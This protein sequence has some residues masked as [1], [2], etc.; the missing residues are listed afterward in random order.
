MTMVAKTSI[1]F[2]ALLFPVRDQFVAHAPYQGKD[3]QSFQIGLFR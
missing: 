2:L 3:C 1:P